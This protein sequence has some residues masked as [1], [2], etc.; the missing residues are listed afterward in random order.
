MRCQYK[1]RHPSLPKEGT[2]R[3]E[4]QSSNTL[5]NSA[6]NKKIRLSLLF[7]TPER[8]K[9]P[10]QMAGLYDI[11]GVCLGGGEISY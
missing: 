11:S 5:Y 1:I 3:L 6:D 4:G 10:G 7:D 8:G 9:T 2:L